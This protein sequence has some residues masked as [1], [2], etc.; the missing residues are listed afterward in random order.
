MN[1]ECK[2]SHF[3]AELERLGATGSRPTSIPASLRMEGDGRFEMFYAPFDHVNVAAKV[4]V[5]GITPGLFQALIALETAAQQLSKGQPA[6]IVLREAKMAASFA[7]ATRSNLVSLLDHVGLANKLGIRTTSHLWGAHANLAHF[8]SALRYPIFEHGRNYSGAGITRHPFL[9]KQ[10]DKWFGAECRCLPN[11][12]FVPLG[13]AAESVCDRMV[14]KGFISRER[15][16]AGLPHPS[17]ANIERIAYFLGRKEARLLSAKTNGPR[18]DDCR[19]RL[20][21]Q[22]SATSFEGA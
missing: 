20:I 18:L 13:S 10:A 17:P 14:T 9:A 3:A 19:T 2:F 5:V 11:A 1:F 7:G 21:A 22:I 8:T 16:L 12:L 15:V 6:E 4:V